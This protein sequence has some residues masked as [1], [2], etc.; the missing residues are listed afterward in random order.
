MI[1]AIR[2]FGRLSFRIGAWFTDYKNKLTFLM[3]VETVKNHEK[4]ITAAKNLRIER[5]QE[6]DL[7]QQMVDQKNQ[8]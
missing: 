8:V 1:V 5:E 7:R 6:A 2:R 4:M 3:Q